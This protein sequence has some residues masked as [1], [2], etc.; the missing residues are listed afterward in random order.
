MMVLLWMMLVGVLLVACGDEPASQPQPV[1]EQARQQQ[2]QEEVGQE[3]E[4]VGDAAEVAD[5]PSE[6]IA[7]AEALA[8]M[9][10]EVEAEESEAQPAAAVQAEPNQTDQP[11][12]QPRGDLTEVAATVIEEESVQVRPGL[13][14]RVIDRLESG[15]SVL[16]LNRVDGWVRISYGDGLEG[17]VGTQALDLDD[18][19]SWQI[20][21]Q[22]PPPLLAEWR[23]AQYKVMGRSADGVTVRMLTNTVDGAE[24]IGA[25]N[26]E[27]TLLADDLTLEDLPILIANETVVFPGNDFRVGQ[28]KVLPEASEWMWLPWGWLLAYNDEYIWQWRPETD[29]L[30]LIRRPPGPKISRLSPNGQHLAFISCDEQESRYCLFKDMHILPLDG[31]P[32][33]SVRELMLASSEVDDID[34]WLRYPGNHIYWSKDGRSVLLSHR[35]RHDALAIVAVFFDAGGTAK[36]LTFRGAKDCQVYPPW[37]GTRAVRLSD[38]DETVVAYTTCYNYDD[39]TYGDSGA[40]VFDGDGQFVRIEARPDPEIERTRQ[41]ELVRSAEQGH[42]LGNELDVQFSRGGGRAMVIDYEK[43]AI[44]I[45]DADSRSVRLVNQAHGL[46]DIS[47][48]EASFVTWEMYWRD[49]KQVAVLPRYGYDWTLGSLLINLD[50]AEGVSFDY[51]PVSRWPCLRTGAWR[52]DGEFFLSMFSAYVGWSEDDRGRWIDGLSVTNDAISELVVVRADGSR[53]GLIRVPVW[54][55]SAPH[56]IGEWSPSG[57]WLAIG[58]HRRPGGCVFAS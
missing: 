52:P 31:S 14:W 54:K 10:Q 19:E 53:A 51:G 22:Q 33:L 50:S 25:P 5:R 18:V 44:W 13:N 45:Y 8:E 9:P 55:W 4:E 21:E 26:D 46:F 24:I 41:L 34:D 38:P 28:G 15:A 6:P 17:W 16:A 36:L 39:A 11:A 37:F 30:E 49:D 27:V 12:D 2:A 3:A 35:T 32:A 42:E 58:G 7:E 40:L 43:H 56:S 29:Q 57:E 1:S 20:R 47:K 23:G 48:Q